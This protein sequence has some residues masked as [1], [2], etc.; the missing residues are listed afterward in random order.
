MQRRQFLTTACATG[1]A[2]ASLQVGQA[3]QPSDQP[4]FIDFRMITCPNAERLETLVKYNGEAISYFGK[5]GISPVG[6]WVADAQLNAKEAAY[7]KKYDNMMFCL[8]PHPTLN[9]TVEL[10]DKLRS[11]AAYQESYAAR[12]QGATSKNPMFTSHER[13]LFRCYPEFPQVEIPSLSPNRIYQLRMYR[14]FSF[15]RSR[16][17]VRQMTTEGGVLDLFAICDMKPV[18]MSTTLYGSYM[19]SIVFMLSFESEEHK[20]DAWAKFFDHPIWKK[21]STDPQYADTVTEVINIFLKPCQ[22]SQI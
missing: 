15:E 22:G 14:S 4:H 5:Y 18:F 17:K 8:I 19:P 9:S 21:L 11:D 12:S 6:L 20:T 13:M 7:D 1:L 10:T 3:A 16:A 2:A